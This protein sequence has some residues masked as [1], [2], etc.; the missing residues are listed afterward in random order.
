MIE[1][2]ILEAPISDRMLCNNMGQLD[3]LKNKIRVGGNWFDFD[4]RWKVAII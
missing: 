4:E 1:V 3:K 2:K